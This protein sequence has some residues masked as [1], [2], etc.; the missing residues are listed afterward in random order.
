[1]KNKTQIMKKLTLLLLLSLSTVVHAQKTEYV[2]TIC[3]AQNNWYY[4]G[5]YLSIVT[6]DINDV[7]Y[8]IASLK[9]SVVTLKGCLTVTDELNDEL[10]KKNTAFTLDHLTMIAKKD[11]RKYFKQRKPPIETIQSYLKAIIDLKLNHQ[12]QIFDSL[13]KWN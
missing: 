1:M 9:E 4:V 8:I 11:T 5:Y 6:D 3:F 10:N 2:D 13:K 12:R 7:E